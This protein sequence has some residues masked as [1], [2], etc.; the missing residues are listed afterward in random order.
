MSVSVVSSQP[1]VDTLAGSFGS[2]GGIAISADQ[3]GKCLKEYTRAQVL[4]KG[5]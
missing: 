1:Q 2:I 4:F 3:A 5:I